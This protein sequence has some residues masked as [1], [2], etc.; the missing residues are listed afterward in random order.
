LWAPIAFAATSLIRRVLRR[1]DFYR[2]AWHPPL[3]DLALFV[4]MLGVVAALTEQIVEI[5]S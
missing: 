1:V 2:L 3:F 5:G 4:I